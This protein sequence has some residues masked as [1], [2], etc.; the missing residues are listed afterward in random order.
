MTK[1]G[2]SWYEGELKN[3]LTA[4]WS[5][6]TFDNRVHYAYKVKLQCFQH[7]SWERHFFR[8]LSFFLFCLCV[9]VSTLHSRIVFLLPNYVWL[10]IFT[11][12]H[13]RQCNA[14]NWMVHICGKNIRS[15]QFIRQI[16]QNEVSRW[17]R[18][19]VES[20]IYCCTVHIIISTNVW[21]KNTHSNHGQIKASFIIH[22][23]GLS[24]SK[25]WFKKAASDTEMIRGPIAQGLAGK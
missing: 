20:I 4:F 24:F 25:G 2:I 11:L 21:R 13:Q 1:K 14:W 19:F 8:F 17:L 22:I 5:N 9:Y 10:L 3:K 12:L 6:V 15:S 7:N 23:H 16:Q 18:I